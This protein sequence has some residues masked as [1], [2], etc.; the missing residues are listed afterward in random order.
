MKLKL[1][2]ASML[3]A[4]SLVGCGT[5]EKDEPKTMTN[6]EAPS[7]F[8]YKSADNQVVVTVKGGIAGAEFDILN[9][10]PEENEEPIILATG[11]LD[12]KGAATV[13]VTGTNVDTTTLFVR[14]KYITMPSA[15]VVVSNGTATLDYKAIVVTSTSATTKKASRIVK[16]GFDC[17]L[18]YDS[19][20]IPY[21][22]STEMVNQN[23]ENLYPGLVKRLNNAFPEG[24]ALSSLGTGDIELL[25]GDI[26]NDF[27]VKITV[28]HE[29]AGY[30]NT[31]G[32]Y[33]YTKGNAPKSA[34]DIKDIK[35][36]F[37]NFETGY[38]NKVGGNVLKTGDTVTLP[39][40]FAKDTYIGFVV[41]QDGW[42]QTT[43]KIQDKVR[44]YTNSAL[45]GDKLQHTA[46]FF[47]MYSMKTVIGMEDLTGG[48][49]K[50]YNDIMVMMNVKVDPKIVDETIVK[51]TIERY[52]ASGSNTL[53]YE[54]LWPGKGDY[55]FN[56]QVVNF[57]YALK[58]TKQLEQ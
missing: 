16:D 36:V 12:P 49:D 57:N 38:L 39:V 27:E 15:Q 29:G 58:S 18:N 46:A 28:V 31:L 11:T 56:D 35:I 7:G 3:V 19:W 33:T 20:G 14:S 30:K 22:S 10:I 48:G 1:M 8:A 26:K 13:T 43:G 55:D 34:A 42:N 21:R 24:K 37:P 5:A 51:E 23:L 53:V 54:D 25:P 45:N 4:L 2:L 32:Y 40:K 44:F 50:D 52:P 9:T 17:V 6:L 41:L 47:D